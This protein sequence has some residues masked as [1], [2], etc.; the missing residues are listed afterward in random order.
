M[1]RKNR[2]GNGDLRFQAYSDAI[3][4]GNKPH[5]SLTTGCELTGQR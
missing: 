5:Y 4:F 3:F 2:F 1:F